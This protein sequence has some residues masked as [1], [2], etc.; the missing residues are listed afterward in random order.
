MSRRSL[1]FSQDRHW[2]L[3]GGLATLVVHSVRRH[4]VLFA[5]VWIAV[6]GA[7]LGL[8]ELL[9]RTYSAQVTIQVSPV[10]VIAGVGG[11]PGTA[12]S[13]P[14]KYASEA[15]LS[16][17]NLVHLVETTDLMEQW[18]RVEAPLPRLVNQLR[19]RLHPLGPEERLEGF[20]DLLEKRL[21]VES[22]AKTVTI[23]ALLPDP[24]LAL[25]MVESAQASFLVARQQEEIATVEEGIGI[26]EGRILEARE[27]LDRALDNL[28]LARDER[29]LRAGGRPL[30]LVGPVS[31]LES[32]AGR[33]GAELQ[34]DLQ[35]RQRELAN[36][37]E[38]RRRR[39]AELEAKLE[40]LRAVYAETHPAV[41]D[42]RER[43]EEARRESPE[44][45]ALQRTLAPLEA[46]VRQRGLLSDVPLRGARERSSPLEGAFG[47]TDLQE[48]RDP[49]ISNAKAALLHAYGAYNGLQD[50]LQAVRLERDAARAAFKYRYVVM[51]PAQ[52]PRGPVSPKPTLVALVSLVAGLVLAGFAPAFLDLASG[53]FVESWQVEQTLGVPLLGTLPE[54]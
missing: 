31:M 35:T 41:V 7:S 23:G 19:E 39:I 21:W 48:E 29:R 40:D 5:L 34:H 16:H 50:R 1:A 25:A 3:V 38:A 44:I 13:T 36:L 42:T 37:V 11:G 18:A 32:P 49:R 9:P 12:A 54:V 4:R 27:A 20:V 2:A 30:R 51:R 24:D 53:R 46:E 28:Q 6:V 8:L 33:R 47:S 22:D 17:R 14:G 52:L 15:L 10:Q 45:S 43:L 26:L